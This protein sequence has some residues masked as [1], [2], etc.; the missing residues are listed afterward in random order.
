[1]LFRIVHISRGFFLSTLR[2][3]RRGCSGAVERSL[4]T[5]FLYPY[6]HA[7]ATSEPQNSSRLLV[8]PHRGGPEPIGNGVGE[9]YHRSPHDH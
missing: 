2:A 8:K 1:M 9:T 6:R 7:E 5:Q 3:V 4:R